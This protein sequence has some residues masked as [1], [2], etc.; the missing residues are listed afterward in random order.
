MTQAVSIL[1]CALGGEGGGV[2]ADWLVEVAHVANYPAQATSIPGVAQRT[3]ATTYYL[4]IFPVSNSQL[5]GQ[6]PVLGLNPLPGRLDALISSELLETA[7]QIGNGLASSDR[8]CVIS[9]S[10]RTLTTA[11]K[12]VMG[13]GRRDDAPLFNV[14]AANSLRHHVLDMAAMCHQ[15]GTMVSAVML[16][17]IAASGLLPF[18]RRHYETVL[19]G[20]SN[21]AKASLRGFTLAFDRVSLQ[22]EQ[23][24]YVEKVLA[25]A[26]PKASS[27]LA[28]PAQLA[29]QFPKHT[30][31]LLAL[32]FDRL[33]QYQSESYA[34][35]MVTRLSNLKAIELA[36]PGAS[37]ECPVTTET[38]RWLALWMA[39]DDIIQVAHL[40]SK[41]TRWQRVSTEVKLKDGELLKVY[42]HFKPG[43]PEIAA[44]LPS[45]W[46]Q[47]LLKWD[48]A[49]IAN[50]KAAWS[51]PIKLAR[52]S[53]VGLVSLRILAAMRVLRPIG[54]R[55]ATEQLLIEEWLDGISQACVRSPEMALEVAR[56]GQLIKGYGSTNER[57]KDNLLHILRTVCQPAA[58]K[59]LDEQT[60]AVAQIRKAALQDE[61]GQQFDLALLQHGAPARPVKEQPILWM[62]N[63]RLTKAS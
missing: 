22:R 57:G 39:F 6:K 3:G 8:T 11:E 17:A 21:A 27:T 44:M 31:E 55:Y 15:A 42:D 26:A 10:S 2:L 36:S 62:K 32:A 38:I 60:A 61:K 20:N 1:L 48:R 37:A 34:Q 58:D 5:N 40:K 28:L 35:L 4:E 41:A 63:P 51:M 46:A 43:V 9:S 13:D 29:Q 52:H 56:C 16:G 54:S 53:V 14:I 47:A 12:M 59:S 25:P 23:A 45:T 30:H 50:G 7:R 49:R 33:V 18:E 24:Q 19:S